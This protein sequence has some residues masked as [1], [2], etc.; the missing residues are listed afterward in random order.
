M[1]FSREWDENYRAGRHY[2]TWPWS[3][4]ISLTHQYAAPHDGYTKVLELGCGAGANIPF[5]L[6]LGADYAAVDGSPAVIEMLKGRFPEMSEYLMVADFTLHLPFDG[7]FD[8]VVDRSSLISNT[9]EGMIRGLQLAAE[10][11]RPGARFIAVDW[12]STKHEGATL[13]EAVD[14]NTRVHFPEHSDLAGIGKIHFCDRPHIKM[15]LSAAGLNLVML[16]HKVAQT[17]FPDAGPVRAWWN[18]V[19]EKPAG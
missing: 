4:L 2:S 6:A 12:F 18:F 15:L 14:A 13:G 3:D 19:A 10:K 8:L 11:M 7:P 17:E 16:N 5:F 9:T 1:S